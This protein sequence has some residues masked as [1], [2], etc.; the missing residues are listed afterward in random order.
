GFTNVHLIRHIILNLTLVG[1][2]VPKSL[3][4][5]WGLNNL[6]IYASA[7]NFL[8]KTKYFGYD[9]EVTTYEEFS[10]SQGVTYYEYPKP[11]IFMAGINLNF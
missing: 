1:F 6:R 8:L 10:F 2:T 9:P 5:K 7:Q 11:R 4:S 3:T